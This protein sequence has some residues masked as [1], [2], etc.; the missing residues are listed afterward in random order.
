MSSIS[1]T[2]NGE[3]HRFDAADQDVTVT[4]VLT[5]LD[6]GDVRVAVEVNGDI[7]PRDTHQDHALR[8]GDR[9]EIVTFVG[10]G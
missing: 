6:L 3:N 10:G 8:D 4:R 2:V 9:I 1:I 5:Q 7:V